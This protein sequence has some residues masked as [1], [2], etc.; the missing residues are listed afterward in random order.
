[1]RR[2][3]KLLGFIYRWVYLWCVVAFIRVYHRTD[4]IVL[5]H[6]ST[7]DAA[8][9][10]SFAD[11]HVEQCGRAIFICSTDHQ[12]IFRRFVAHPDVTLIFLSEKTCQ[13]I[14]VA[15]QM[16]STAFFG[17]RLLELINPSA[18]V[19]PAH[20]ALH[21]EIMQLISLKYTG[22]DEGIFY[23]EG[24][25]TV[26]SLSSTTRQKEPQY[27]EIDKYALSDILS[28]F[29]VAPNN[30]ALINPICYTS[31][32]IST[33][34]WAGIALALS[35]NGFTV[36]FNGQG[37]L[38]DLTNSTAITPAGF[39]II[40]LPA[41]LG[42]LAGQTVGLVCGRIGGGFNLLHTFLRPK[43]SLLVLIEHSEVGSDKK[44]DMRK[45]DIMRDLLSFNGYSADHAVVLSLLDGVDI[46]YA[47]TMATLGSHA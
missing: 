29:K 38:S 43:C 44:G 35:T 41:H 15:W 16:L 10:A 36:I 30:I 28:P 25:R 46:A 20:V 9:I 37:N 7:A 13:R 11:S 40:R 3:R 8:F 14:R 21:P 18:F 1:M 5:A 4:K 2:V 45:D 33:D 47:K 22:T 26:L 12:E 23:N 27:F 31:R 32:N 39:P 34:A 6:G 17:N 24:L 19:L 42:P